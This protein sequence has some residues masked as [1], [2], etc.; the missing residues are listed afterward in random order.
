MVSLTNGRKTYMGETRPDTSALIFQ[1]LLGQGWIKEYEDRDT[2]SVPMTSVQSSEQIPVQLRD[3]RP[4]ITPEEMR[5]REWR[6]SAMPDFS[7][8]VSNDSS[9]A[10][11]PTNVNVECGQHNGERVEGPQ[12]TLQNTQEDPQKLPIERIKESSGRIRRGLSHS[13]TTRDELVTDYQ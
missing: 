12:P 10:G 8:P 1:P 4:Y 6:E 5:A 9:M 7:D 2:E 13:I 11:Q 3:L